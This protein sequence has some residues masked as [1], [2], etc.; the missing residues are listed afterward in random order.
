MTENVTNDAERHIT[1]LNQ[2]ENQ[3]IAAVLVVGFHHA[4]GPIVEFCIPP[5]PQHE[6]HSEDQPQKTLEKL[7]LP[8][9]WSFLPFLALPDGAH[10]KDEDFAYFHL[11]PVPGWSVAETTLFGIS[12]NRQ[13]PASDLEVKTPDITRSIVQKAVVVLAKQPIFGPLRQKLAV[14]TAG[15]F[16]QRNFTKLDMLYVL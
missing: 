2:Q 12:C 1:T 16:N 13:I 14:I 5:L 6:H 9:E 15:W 8:E 10:Q 7:E 11:P 4:F 3:Q